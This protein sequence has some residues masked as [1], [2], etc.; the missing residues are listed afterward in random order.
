MGTEGGRHLQQLQ[1][2]SCYTCKAARTTHLFLSKQASLS[3]DRNLFNHN[4]RIVDVVFVWR[5]PLGLTT[6][7]R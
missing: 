2:K 7:I 6:P 3:L 4:W 1:K 5:R